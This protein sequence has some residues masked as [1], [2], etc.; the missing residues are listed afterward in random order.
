MSK[1]TDAICPECLENVIDVNDGRAS[2]V[3]GF[4]P[5]LKMGWML[6]LR[7]GADPLLLQSAKMTEAG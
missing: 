7:P 1:L 2:C 3:T 6:S 5:H 4:C